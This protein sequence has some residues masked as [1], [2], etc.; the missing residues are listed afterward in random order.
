MVLLH[1]TVTCTPDGAISTLMQ[2]NLKDTAQTENLKGNDADPEMTTPT[3]IH[4]RLADQKAAGAVVK[5]AEMVFTL[6]K[7]I[8]A[9]N[10]I[11]EQDVETMTDGAVAMIEIL[12]TGGTGI[13]TGTE[14][15][16]VEGIIQTEMIDIEGVIDATGMTGQGTTE[17]AAV[18]IAID[19]GIV[20][21]EE[22]LMM[23]DEE[24][25]AGVREIGKVIGR[26]RRAICLLHMPFLT[27]KRKAHDMFVKKRR[28]GW[29][30]EVVQVE[31]FRGVS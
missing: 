20:E 14:T 12:T 3:M 25:A 23:I 10:R 1:R 18:E 15:T 26:S 5:A 19:I 8:V 2:T 29:P 31:Q 27:Y 11:M 30:N 21:A 6:P 17:E 24:E 7:M 9:T 16:N 4:L 28:S 13:E 22:T